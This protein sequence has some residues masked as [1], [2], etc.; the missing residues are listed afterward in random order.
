MTSFLGGFRNEYPRLGFRSSPANNLWLP[1]CNIAVI[2]SAAKDLLF[3]EPTLE[4][5]YFV[6]L[7][8]SRSGTLYT[9]VTNNLTRRVWQHREGLVPGFTIQYRIHRLVYFECFGDV[10]M[11][12]AREKQIKGWLR[13]KK[14]ALIEAQNPTW[15]DLA[16]EWFRS[17]GKAAKAEKERKQILRCAQDDSNCGW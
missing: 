13:A 17:A 6:Y 1:K 5:R 14:V 3:L 2:L 15:S 11:A 4:K 12:I 7:L 16:E 10:R 8:A 9:G